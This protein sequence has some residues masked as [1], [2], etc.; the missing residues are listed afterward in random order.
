MSLAA[1]AS[2]SLGTE[3]NENPSKIIWRLAWPAVVLN[4]L[5]VINIF[6]DTY[7]VGHLPVAALTAV[8]SAGNITFLIF[9]ISMAL[10]TA[11]T[12]LVSRAFGGKN[13]KEYKMATRQVLSLALYGGI[14]FM[15]IG[16]S[17]NPF[18]ANILIP[19]ADIDAKRLMVQYLFYAMLSAPALLILESLAGAL[20]AIGDTKS[21][22]RI[23]GL[24]IFLHVILNYFLILPETTFNFLGGLTVPGLGLGVSGAGIALAT[25]QWVAAIIYIGWTART[26][27]GNCWHIQ[28]PVFAWAKR[29]F[30]IAAPAAA[31]WLLRVVMYMAFTVILTTIPAG[32]HAIAAMRAGFAVESIAFMPAIGLVIAAAT[33]VGQSLGM[34]NP[35]RAERLGWLASHH[36]AVVTTIVGGILF[37]FADPIANFLVTNKPEISAITANYIRF[38][39]ASETFFAYALVMMGGMQGAGDTIRPLWIT[40]ITMFAI[41]LPLSWLLA[42]PMSMGADGCWI[43]MSVTQCMQGLLAVYIFKQGKWKTVKV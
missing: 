23:S 31:T 38:I 41:R 5:Q 32:S 42:H 39:C 4:S 28:F 25:S 15:L 43:A 6:L 18:F 34:Q 7:F 33:L 20:N 26:P 8:G 17:L 36:A 37:Y 24:Q 13:E 22:M 35:R 21:P 40:V 9:S 2:L 3:H 16:F 1:E 10:S 27:L 19:A 12:A 29:I 14:I 11:S 30:H